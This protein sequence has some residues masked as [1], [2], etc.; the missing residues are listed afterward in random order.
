MSLQS[1]LAELT[2]RVAAEFKTV[3]S[4]I[5]SLPSL[6]TANKTNLVAAINEAGAPQTISLSGT[7][8]SLSKGGGTVTLPSGGRVTD[9]GTYLTIT[10]D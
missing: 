10:F 4:R 8:L 7:N 1:H 2:N 3:H 9:N 6:T 5:G